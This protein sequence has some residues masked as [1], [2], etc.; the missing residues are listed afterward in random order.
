MG[1]SHVYCDWCHVLFGPDD[2]PLVDPDA[3]GA[4]YHPECKVRCMAYRTPPQRIC[5]RDLEHGPIDH[6]AA[7]TPRW[8]IRY[9][10]RTMPFETR[11]W[12]CEISEHERPLRRLLQG[13]NLLA[14]PDKRRTPDNLPGY[15][16]RWRRWLTQGD[17]VKGEGMCEPAYFVAQLARFG[18]R[19][20]ACWCP[21]TTDQ[22][23]V[24]VLIK[25][26]HEYI[27]PG[28]AEVPHD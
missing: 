14:N 23:H 25:L 27:E 4:A 11:W 20:L 26:W 10:G 28:K 12:N 9:C 6:I 7:G 16:N 19:Q 5:I 1:N 2:T 8:Y 17:G 24:E 18:G 22:C 13:D 15:E 21:M 3:A